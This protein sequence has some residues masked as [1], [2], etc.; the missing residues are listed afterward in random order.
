MFTGHLCSGKPPWQR[1]GGDSERETKKRNTPKIFRGGEY[2]A[3]TRQP[4][5]RHYA[6]APLLDDLERPS[7][8]DLTG[9]Q[10]GWCLSMR[11][12][13]C[14]AV[15]ST[16]ACSWM[17]GLTVRDEDPLGRRVVDAPLGPLL[18]R[19]L[20]LLLLLLLLALLDKC[21]VFLRG[22]HAHV[23]EA[24]TWPGSHVFR[25]LGERN[26][27]NQRQLKGLIF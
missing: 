19:L 2:F 1:Q 5:R 8:R 9:R 4:P 24:A 7:G 13:V 22:V 26:A 25:Q 17:G 23:T 18:L 14:T 15:G 3:Q 11:V 10:D 20:L 16:A 27:R 21:F 12:R 6:A